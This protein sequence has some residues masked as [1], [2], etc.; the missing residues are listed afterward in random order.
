MYLFPRYPLTVI[1]R[2]GIIYYF[3]QICYKRKV[4][5]C[6]Y[7]QQAKYFRTLPFHYSPCEICTADEYG[8]FEY[9]L[10]IT[11]DLIMELLSKGGRIEVIEPESLR[12]EMKTNLNRMFNRYK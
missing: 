8:D 12:A 3:Y 9:T 1:G 4:V 5:L 10:Y 11:T 6:A 7:G 2:S